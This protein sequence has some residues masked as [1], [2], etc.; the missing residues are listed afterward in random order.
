[1]G[2]WETEMS[3]VVAAPEQVQAAAHDLA[4]VRALLAGSSVSAAVPTTAVAAAAQDGV[5]GR[6]RGSSVTTFANAVQTG[7]VSAA[8]AAVLDT[9]AVVANGFLNGQT[10]LPLSV[11]VDL[12]TLLFPTTLNIPLDGIL[13]PAAPYAALVDGS[14]LFGPGVTLNSTVTGTPISGILPGLLTFL[15]ADLAAA[16]GGPP[17][18]LSHPLRFSS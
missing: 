18:L 15:P 6:G 11:T 7:N 5:S 13:A 17:L 4:G 9:P 10:T 16:I 2:R 14:S 3:F 8:A 1:M 12:D